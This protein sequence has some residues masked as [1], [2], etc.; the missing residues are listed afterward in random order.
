ML[1]GIAP[2]STLIEIMGPTKKNA[3]FLG[4]VENIS[5][6]CSIATE[7]LGAKRAVL[8]YEKDVFGRLSL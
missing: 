1:R 7:P 5:Y 2:V 3:D 4:C 8:F 6:I